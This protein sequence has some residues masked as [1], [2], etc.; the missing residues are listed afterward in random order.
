MSGEPRRTTRGPAHEGTGVVAVTGGLE[1]QLSGLGDPHLLDR[2][3]SVP[4]G[5]E[6]PHEVGTDDPV[7]Q[8]L[9][10]VPLLVEATV[11]DADPVQLIRPN[12]ATG[13]PRGSVDTSEGAGSTREANSTPGS[14]GTYS[15]RLNRRILDSGGVGWTSPNPVPVTGWA[16]VNNHSGGTVPG[17]GVTWWRPKAREQ[18]CQSLRKRW[19]P[20]RPG[21]AHR[22]PARGS[23]RPRRSASPDPAQARTEADPRMAIRP[24]GEPDGRRHGGA[25][26]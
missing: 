16:R 14:G 5:A 7:G 6:H 10:G 8:Q 13:L 21:W 2:E 20:G 9:S 22:Q 26:C 17:S 12:R 4:Q 15:G 23:W 11:D 3:S 19:A 24:A 25:R 1:I 18:P